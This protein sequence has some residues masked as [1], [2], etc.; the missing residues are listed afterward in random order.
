[1]TAPTNLPHL[2]TRTS[3]RNVDRDGS[4]RGSAAIAIGQKDTIAVLGT[5]CLTTNRRTAE[6]KPWAVLRPA[7]RY[8][9]V[10]REDGL[11]GWIDVPPAERVVGFG[12]QHIHL[13]RTRYEGES[14]SG[15]THGR[16]ESACMTFRPPSTA[17]EPRRYRI[18]VST[19]DVRSGCGA[20]SRRAPSARAGVRRRASSDRLASRRQRCAG[21]RQGLAEASIHAS[22][23][24]GI[25]R[26]DPLWPDLG[27]GIGFFLRVYSDTFRTMPT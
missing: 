15:D 11:I 8:D 16:S 17:S 24:C 10:D 27:L 23:N 6:R 14:I 21:A 19:T 2:T 18:P 7:S 5:V 4:F 20:D 3:G 22:P 13:S 25:R 1:M 9:V 12:A 26:S